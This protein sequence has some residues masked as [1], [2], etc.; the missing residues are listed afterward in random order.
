MIS[1]GGLSVMGGIKAVIRH[2]QQPIDTPQPLN[3]RKRLVYT[4][5]IVRRILTWEA[6]PFYTLRDKVLP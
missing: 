4:L 5:L 3:T 6:G 1:D 2:A